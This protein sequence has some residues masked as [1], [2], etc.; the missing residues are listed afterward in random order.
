ML[1]FFH[2]F[3]PKIYIQDVFVYFNLSAII[4]LLLTAIL[5]ASGSCSQW[6][7]AALTYVVYSTLA[8]EYF[9]LMK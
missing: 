6:V 3:K 1:L 8:L 5:R 4:L 9:S 7:F 2:R